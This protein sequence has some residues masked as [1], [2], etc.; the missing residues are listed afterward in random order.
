MRFSGP[1][2]PAAERD[3]YPRQT[4]RAAGAGQSS[5]AADRVIRRGSVPSMSRSAEAMVS[6]VKRG[7]AAAGPAAIVGF[8]E[9]VQRAQAAV[10]GLTTA[11]RR[12]RACS[13]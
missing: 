4:P 10:C 5:R 12:R 6:H 1:A 8:G 3:R 7:V 11:Y 13:S 2:S 9:R